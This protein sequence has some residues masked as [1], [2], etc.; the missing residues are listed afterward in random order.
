MKKLILCAL[1][2][3][4]CLSGC[5]LF[6]DKVIASL[7]PYA[8]REFFTCGGFQDST[9]YAKYYFMTL[10]LDSNPY[11]SMISKANIAE[12]KRYIY[13]FEQVLAGHNPENQVVV[14][15]DFDCTIISEGDCLY[16]YED[17]DYPPFG[18]YNIY[19]LDAETKVLYYFHNNI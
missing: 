17:S 18:C 9:D 15:Y 13:D 1:G 14:N 3:A 2:L 7:G 11:F 4:L 8:K 6:R 5:Y 19:F 12:L 10:E 16:I